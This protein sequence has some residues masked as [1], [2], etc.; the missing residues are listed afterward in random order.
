MLEQ[1][2]AQPR[3]THLDADLRKDPLGFIE[4]RPY[5]IIGDDA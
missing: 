1:P 3:A 2:L 4:D 5:E